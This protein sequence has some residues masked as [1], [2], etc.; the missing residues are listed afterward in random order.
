MNE[1]VV[2]EHTKEALI[3]RFN[4]PKERNPLSIFVLEKLDSILDSTDPTTERII[5]TGA[6]EVFAS[7]ADLREIAQVTEKNARKFALRGQI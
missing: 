1:A 4:R 6:A 5:F 2:V 3:V 7:G